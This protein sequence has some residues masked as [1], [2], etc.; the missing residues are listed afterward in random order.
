MSQSLGRVRTLMGRCRD[1]AVASHSAHCYGELAS[2]AG[3]DAAGRSV[4]TTLGKHRSEALRR[5]VRLPG[6][7]RE[8]RQ[9]VHELA[10]VLPYSSS[11][12]F[13]GRVQVMTN[14]TAILQSQRRLAQGSA[15]LPDASS[16]QKKGQKRQGGPSSGN[17]PAKR[18]QSSSGGGGGDNP[19]V[20]TAPA[21]SSQPP[22]TASRKKRSRPRHS[23]ASSSQSRPPTAKGFS[24]PKSGQH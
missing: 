5:V 18:H 15:P 17:T 14:A 12:L 24:G 19:P 13:G 22:T 3:V 11:S 21:T 10:L 23:R 8:V 4:R 7:K 1:A 16:G 9:A 2:L 6:E 20:S